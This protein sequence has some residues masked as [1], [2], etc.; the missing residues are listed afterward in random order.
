MGSLSFK[1]ITFLFTGGLGLT[2]LFFFLVC[3]TFS[4]SCLAEGSDNV[5]ARYF[6]PN[7]CRKVQSKCFVVNTLNLPEPLPIL[8][9][10]G[11]LTTFCFRTVAGGSFSLVSV[12][13]S[14]SFSA[15]GLSV[16]FSSGGSGTLTASL[17][18]LRPAI[19]LFC[20]FY[21]NSKNS[22]NYTIII[23]MIR[24]NSNKKKTKSHTDI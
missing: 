16:L 12:S 20:C 5:G 10:L 2:M 19:K 18:A 8:S 24:G 7:V 11:K 13:C 22:N 21:I 23:N 15:G 3:C 17:V 14:C 6:R 4:R 1:W 9:D